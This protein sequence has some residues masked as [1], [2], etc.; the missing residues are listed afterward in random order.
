M[1]KL[2]LKSL[3]GV[4]LQYWGSE[5]SWDAI[6]ELQ[7]RGSPAALALA[8]GLAKCRNPRKR[9]L[10]LYMASQLRQRAKGVPGGSIEYAQEAT[11]A[12][13]LAGLHDDDRGVLHAAV[14]G[15]GHRPHRLALPELIKLAAHPDQEIRLAVA[16]ALGSYPEAESTEALLALATDES[17][18][19]RDWATFGIGSLQEVDNPWVRDLLWANLQDRDEDVRGEAL[20]GLARRKDERIIP[21]L[22]ERLDSRCRVYELH[23]AELLASPLLLKRLNEIK[24]AVADADDVDS[25]WHGCLLDAI[26]ACADR[27]GGQ[28]A[29]PTRPVP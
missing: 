13:L 23:A 4:A 19:V 3:V 18:A 11:Q 29:F 24:D 8:R 17:D 21:G 25:Y 14:S 7:M 15:L 20:V 9:A 12:M 2:G 28:G 26:A 22:L 27:Q 5:D 10:G 16:I 1:R 6:S